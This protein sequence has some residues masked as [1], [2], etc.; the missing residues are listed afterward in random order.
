M[1]LVKGRPDD[2]GADPHNFAGRAAAMDPAKDRP[3][4]VRV[5]P[6]EQLVGH[7]H[8]RGH[9]ARQLVGVRGGVRPVLRAGDRCQCRGRR[10]I[11]DCPRRQGTRA[12]AN[13]LPKPRRIVGSSPPGS[14]ARAQDA[15]HLADRRDRAGDGASIAA[16]LL[17]R[18]GHRDVSDLVGG[19]AAWRLALTPTPGN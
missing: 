12:S 18:S 4:R 16:S 17:R 14:P 8:V 6:C 9:A 10:L 15:A 19:E 1:E 3:D 2:G 5:G 13:A 11:D 7:L